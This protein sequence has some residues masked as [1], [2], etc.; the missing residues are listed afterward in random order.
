M[1][2]YNGGKYLKSS[3]SSVLGQTFGDFEFLIIDDAS[4]DN[5]LETV[6]SFQDERIVIHSNERNRGQTKSLN[7]GLT[8]ARGK[9]V[10]RIDADDGAY[11]KWLEILF[12][13]M[14][15]HPEC[16][17]VGAS[18]AVMDAT[19]RTKRIL[20]KP[21]DPAEILFYFLYDTPV[22]HGSVL[23]RRDAILKCGGYDEAFTVAQ[24]YA[25]W[26]ALMRE[27]ECILNVPDV[28][29]NIRHYQDTR[30]GIRND[31]QIE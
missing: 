27:A 4:T 8:L 7:I 22:V 21:T 13:F 23:M 24:D 29:T 30:R 5:S 18:V 25:L 11:S 19:G 12:R 9:Y 14:Q 16:A 17:V 2:V 10:A 15:S 3:I 28:L 6:K 20:R 31:A 26:S 1:T